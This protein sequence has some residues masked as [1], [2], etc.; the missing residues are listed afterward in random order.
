[1]YVEA[2]LEVCEARDVKGLYKKARAGEISEF[3]GISA[4]YEAPQ[5]PEIT[6]H[7]GT[8]SIEESVAAVLEYITPRIRAVVEDEVVIYR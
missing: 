4:P 8:L 2:P 1:M 6:L 7:T 5:N 3:T